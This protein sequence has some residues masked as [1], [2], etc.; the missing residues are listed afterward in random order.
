MSTNPYVSQSIGTIRINSAAISSDHC[1]QILFSKGSI[2]IWSIFAEVHIAK[3]NLEAVKAT[4]G[5]G[6]VKMTSAST[7][8]LFSRRR[9]TARN[10]VN[11]SAEIIDDTPENR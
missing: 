5:E 8:M 11:P 4:G 6:G 1:A 9:P 3:K 7:K 2:L 10:D